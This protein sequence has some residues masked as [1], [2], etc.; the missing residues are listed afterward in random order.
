[1]KFVLL[2]LF[3][4]FVNPVLSGTRGFRREVL[5]IVLTHN[6]EAALSYLLKSML[7]SEYPNNTEVDLL[8]RID[9]Q[10]DGT[11]HAGTNE[12][13]HGFDWTHGEYEVVHTEKNENILGQWLNCAKRAVHTHK[14]F[15]ILEDDLVVSPF[16][17]VW[18]LEARKAFLDHRSVSGI[19]LHR[20]YLIGKCIDGGDAQ[21]SLQV[22][23][24]HP[25]YLYKQ[26]SAWGLA[27]N[28]FHWREFM[29]FYKLVES[30][31]MKQRPVVEGLIST[32]WYLNHEKHGNI[33]SMWSAWWVFYC[34]KHDLFTLYPNL[35]GTDSF[36]VN[37]RLAGSHFGEGYSPAATFP[38]SYTD[39]VFGDYNSTLKLDWDGTPV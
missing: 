33:E 23:R 36:S 12:T 21:Y 32:E 35:P 11:I 5:L 8:V 26:P 24:K 22:D 7:E 29:K 4:I 9:R 20:Q 10:K 3:V 6:R 31:A 18:L 13:A 27:P 30:G 37:R 2:L 38:G 16:Y 19:S 17:F 1:M 39:P 28:P 34:H 14:W 25:Y 15:L